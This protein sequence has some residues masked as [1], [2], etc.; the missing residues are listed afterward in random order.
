MDHSLRA[1]KIRQLR[2]KSARH[3]SYWSDPA[4]G[5]AL[6]S[7]GLH[8]QRRGNRQSQ[9]RVIYETDFSLPLF[10]VDLGSSADGVC[11]AREDRV[12]AG[13]RLLQ[14]RARLRDRQRPM[15]RLSLRRIRDNSA[16]T[17]PRVLGLV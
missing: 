7:G 17:T 14:N 13:N 8:A 12:A 9:R 11:L 1:K 15:P 3:Q 5:T 2:T 16:F 4:A 10:R 6:E